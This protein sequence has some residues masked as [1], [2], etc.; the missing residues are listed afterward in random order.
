ML[1]PV[2]PWTATVQW[3]AICPYC[4][5]TETSQSESVRGYWPEIAFQFPVNRQKPSANFQFGK[6]KVTFL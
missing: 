6:M 5:I 2:T 1:N 3:T 4:E